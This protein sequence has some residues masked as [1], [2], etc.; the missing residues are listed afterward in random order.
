MLKKAKQA[1]LSSLKASGVSTLIHNSKWQ[2]QRLLILAY[3]RID[4]SDEHIWNGS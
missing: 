2:R 3:H 4:V 1:T